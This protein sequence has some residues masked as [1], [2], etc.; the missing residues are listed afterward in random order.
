MLNR[1]ARLWHTVV[2]RMQEWFHPPVHQNPYRRSN[3]HGRHR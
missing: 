2:Q 3:L 1:L